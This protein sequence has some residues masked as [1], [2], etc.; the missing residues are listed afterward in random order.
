MSSAVVK[1]SGI[2]ARGSYGGTAV[3][4]AILASVERSCRECRL[5]RLTLGTDEAPAIATLLS[6]WSLTDFLER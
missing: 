4:E 2:M 1:C 3:G 6:W 5:A